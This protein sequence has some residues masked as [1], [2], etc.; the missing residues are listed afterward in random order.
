MKQLFFA[1]VFLIIIG[2]VL[3]ANRYYNPSY[4][5]SPTLTSSPTPTITPIVPINVLE[6]DYQGTTY[7]IYYSILSG[8]K[9]KL[10][11]NFDQ[12][13]S[14]KSLVKENNCLAAINGGFYTPEGEPL[15]LFITDNKI[16]N[17]EETINK[18]LLTGFFYL[19]EQG[20]PKIGN[21]YFSG[22][23]LVLQAGPLIINNYPLSTIIDE[24]ARRSVIVED[25]QGNYYILAIIVKDDLYLGPSLEDLPPL[26]FS[27]EK[28]FQVS[29]AL[30]LDGG[31]SAVYFGE[32]KIV[33]SELSSVG[34]I[35]CLFN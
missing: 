25:T 30:N 9:I 5:P 15:G 24:Q 17:E 33:L 1:S 3:I 13:L 31:S 4:F 18:T 20:N 14:A 21:T 8:K 35:L 28:P 16:Y 12:K 10:I 6:I 27:I 19:D 7:L 22:S 26:L 2:L 29:T 34:S 32:D 11:P 23:L